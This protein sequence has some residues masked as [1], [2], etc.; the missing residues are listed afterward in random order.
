M[1]SEALKSEIRKRLFMANVRKGDPR[2]LHGWRWCPRCRGDGDVCN[3][4]PGCAIFEPCDRCD[5][6][7]VIPAET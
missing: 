2:T 4:Y 3:E 7:G 1:S 6:E 5:G